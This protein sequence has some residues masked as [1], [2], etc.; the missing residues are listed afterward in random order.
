MNGIIVVD[1]PSGISSSDACLKV[2][3]TLGVRKVGHLGTLDPLATGVLPLCVNEGTKLVQFLT[4][5]E[6]E[7][8]GTLRFGIET[9]TQDSEGKILG[10]SDNIPHDRNAILNTFM[11]FQGEI[12]QTP[13]MYS[14]IKCNGVP[15]YKIARKGECIPRKQRKVTIYDIEVLKIHIPHVTFRVV[16]SSGT[17]IRTLCADIALKLSCCAHLTGLERVRNGD[18]H[19]KQSLKIE[20]FKSCSRQDIIEKHLIL[21]IDAL[22]KMPE[23]IADATMEQ[24]IKNGVQVYTR[25]L[26]THN[27]SEQK[28]GEQVKILSASGNLIA[29]V[30]LLVD[31]DILLSYDPD[32]KAWKILRGFS[33]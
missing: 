12:F 32:T 27:L 15:L 22:R 16:C 13:P 14:A 1:K 18:F 4:R 25:D 9:D 24:K 8:I 2:K 29:V 26:A 6:K 23:V 31:F 28:T 5:C 20:D 3:K 11:S 7:Y 10:T 30:E 21:P 17:Y 33:N 19:I